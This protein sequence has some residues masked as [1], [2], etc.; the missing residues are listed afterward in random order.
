MPLSSMSYLRRLCADGFTLQSGNPKFIVYDDLL[1]SLGAS[2]NDSIKLRKRI[3]SPYDPRYRLWELFLIFLVL[4]SAW[5]CPFEF[6]FLRYL[7]R[8]ICVVDSIVDSFFAIDIML[9]FFVA[10]V[11]R[12]S[13]LLVGD[14]KR[15]AS[16][17][18]S[19][20]FVFDV[21]STFPFQTISFSFNRN[22]DNLSLKLL[23]ML[24]L[25]RLH[26][27]SS[28][29]ARLEK[30]LR[31][32]Y[33]WTRCTKLFSVTI[34]AVHFSGCFNYMIADRYPQP[35]ATWI[36][37]AIP[38]FKQD[39]VWFRYV[40]SIYFSITTLSTTGYGD[41]HAQNTREMLFAICYMF[42]NLGLMAYLIGNMTNL[43]VNWTSR[44][45]N[46]RNTIQDASEFATRN[47]LPKHIKQQMLSHL[48]LRF[49]TEELKQQGALNCLPKAIRSSIAEYLFLPLVQ[50]AYL[51]QGV[52]FNLIFQLVTEMQAEYVP[53]KEDVILEN[54]ASTDLYIIEL[55]TCVDG[56]EKALAK[57]AAEEMFG[58]MGVLC[59]M[60]QPFTVRTTQLTQILRLNKAKLLNAMRESKPDANIIIS[61]LFQKLR[62]QERQHPRIQLNDR[63]TIK[64]RVFE[65]ENNEVNVDEDNNGYV[66]RKAS[67]EHS[68]RVTIHMANLERHLM[69]KMIL[70]PTTLEELLR[71]GGEKFVGHHPTRVVN[72]EDAEI[73]D[74]RVVRDGDHLYLQE[75]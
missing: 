47:K 50:R 19:T 56:N 37:A 65:S 29:F 63:E 12:K 9:T 41:F 53:P 24:R 36:G 11:D 60:P 20:W 72:G 28:L 62:Q 18:L 8:T 38:S 49:K 67:E 15:I 69:A 64:L 44:T 4:Y 73:D 75:T 52:S 5:I 33:F 51:F 48:C 34:F 23:S 6:A 13:Y 74:I 59:H 58:E 40:T 66:E 35:T 7:P 54:E 25:W 26:R 32:N 55:R 10:F 3:I 21:C 39:T 30:D 68:K 42:F 70:L 2:I 61:N 45:R 31:F 71:I 27:V 14:P 43:V 57:V 22:G 1:P 17:Y 46:F 16:R